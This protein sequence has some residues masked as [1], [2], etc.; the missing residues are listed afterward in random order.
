MEMLVGAS[1]GTLEAT[2]SSR[3]YFARG[4]RV[5]VSKA[6]GLEIFV[7]YIAKLSMSI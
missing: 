7:G 3:L 5:A 4:F 1:A 6:S 2:W